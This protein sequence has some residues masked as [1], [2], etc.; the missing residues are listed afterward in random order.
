MTLALPISRR[1]GWVCRH[2][3]R[4]VILALAVWVVGFTIYWQITEYSRFN[5]AFADA[6]WNWTQVGRDPRTL[7][8][9]E[10]RKLISQLASSLPPER[11]DAAGKL[12]S[13]H[14][15][16][17]LWPLIAAMADDEGTRRTC[18][19]S[20]AIG[21]LGDSAAVPALIAAAQ[22][23][24][25]LDLRVCATHS[26]G[27]IGDR[28]AVDFLVKRATDPSIPEGERS[29]AISALG[30]IG[31]PLALPALESIPST[32]T[33]LRSFS[34]SATKQIDLLQGD[35]A[36]NLLAAIGDNTD[37]IHDDWI[38]AQLHRRWDARIA[39]G[40]NE[41]LRANPDFQPGLRLRIAALLTAKQSLERTALQMLGESANQEDRWLAS[42]A[43]RDIESPRSAARN[44]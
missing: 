18:V 14:D 26:L 28:S 19:I 24:G 23:P 38:L 37:W 10:R 17:A 9:Q 5:A 35:A 22:H 43:G 4:A 6:V 3:A 8:P 33:R 13:W 31:F 27:Q 1:L 25:N 41:I 20:Q 29:G 30:E 36:A 32:G 11:W 21:K 42:A 12:A 39:S 16:A 34:A 44:R 15:P 7:A 2:P 40:L